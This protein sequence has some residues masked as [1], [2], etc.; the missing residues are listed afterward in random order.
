MPKLFSKYHRGLRSSSLVASFF[1]LKA[2]FSRKRNRENER[3]ERER[4][5]TLC[6]NRRLHRAPFITLTRHGSLSM[7]NGNGRNKYRKSN[8]VPL[9][10]TL[11]HLENGINRGRFRVA[12]TGYIGFQYRTTGFGTDGAIEK[13]VRNLSCGEEERARKKG[14]EGKRR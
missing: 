6:T 12:R 7:I 1:A 8:Q 14:E 13:A 3:K 2:R 11:L 10:T 5:C 4:I 9:S